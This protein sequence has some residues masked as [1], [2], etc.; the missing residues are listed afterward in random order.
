MKLI[1]GGTLTTYSKTKV[2]VSLV[3]TISWRVTMFACFN[4][5]KS[6]ASRIA[7]NGAPSSSWSL[8]S[9]RATT[10]FVKLKIQ[11]G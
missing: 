2:K 10:W 5:F 4:S 6:D 7:V 8:I 9:F 11:K 3:W 1:T